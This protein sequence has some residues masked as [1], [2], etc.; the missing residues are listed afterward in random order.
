MVFFP[1]RSSA[2]LRRFARAAF[3][4]H[5]LTSLRAIAGPDRKVEFEVQHDGEDGRSFPGDV[6]V[7]RWDREVVVLEGE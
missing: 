7:R 1:P 6:V 3:E 5:V 4:R 2:G